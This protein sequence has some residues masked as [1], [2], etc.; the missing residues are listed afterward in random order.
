MHKE[1]GDFLR[2]PMTRTGK[3]YSGLKYILQIVP[4]NINAL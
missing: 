1:G 2:S 3:I 4:R